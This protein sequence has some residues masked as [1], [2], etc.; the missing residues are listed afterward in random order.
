[1]VASKAKGWTKK[2]IIMKKIVFKKIQT[3]LITLQL[4]KDITAIY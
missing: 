4:V 1:M 2:M 3:Y